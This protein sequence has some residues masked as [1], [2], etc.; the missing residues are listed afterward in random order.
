MFS[1]LKP[2]SRVQH[3]MC[4]LTLWWWPDGV[5]PCR[6][7]WRGPRSHAWS[8]CSSSLPFWRASDGPDCCRQ[9]RAD[10]WRPHRATDP[11]APDPSGPG[12]NQTLNITP[13]QNSHLC[14]YTLAEISHFSDEFSEVQLLKGDVPLLQVHAG[15]TGLAGDGALPLVSPRAG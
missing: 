7:P 5:E 14:T 13:S 2:R 8:A 12:T 1:R 15:L 4:V 3:Q 11:C 6:H 9:S 10:G